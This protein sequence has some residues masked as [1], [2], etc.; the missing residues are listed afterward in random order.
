MNY[1]TQPNPTQPHVI[2]IQ[3]DCISD[4]V[5]SI[6]LQDRTPVS[7]TNYLK[8]EYTCNSI[9]SRSTPFTARGNLPHARQ[10]TCMIYYASVHDLGPSRE[11]AS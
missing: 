2:I 3:G 1:P 11:I 6:A 4:V 7:G 5:F 10:M 9:D 8:L